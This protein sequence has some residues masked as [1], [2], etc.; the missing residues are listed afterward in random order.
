MLTLMPL[1]ASTIWLWPDA[2]VVCWTV[3]APVSVTSPLLRLMVIS[4]DGSEATWR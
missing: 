4:W 1:A 3:K 2:V